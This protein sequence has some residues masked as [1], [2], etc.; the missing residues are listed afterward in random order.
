MQVRRSN[1][2][3][4]SPPLPRSRRSCSPARSRPRAWCQPL[5]PP[6]LAHHGQRLPGDVGSRPGHREHHLV[7]RR[8]RP[9][10]ATC[11]TTASRTTRSPATP[12]TPPGGDTAGNSGNVAVSSSTAATARNHIDLWMTGPFHAIGILRP[13]LA[14]SGFG[15]CADDGDQPHGTP[16]GRSTC[17]AASTTQIAHPD[18][19][20]RLPRPQCHD[21]PR[22]LHHRVAEPADVLRLDRRRPVSR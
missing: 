5:H 19:R 20:D 1:G 2:Y 8:H 16:E 14:T 22:P 17:S 11:S 4:A 15:I 10:R 7:G 9:T 21:R 13:K 12:A 6:I 3:V 18:H